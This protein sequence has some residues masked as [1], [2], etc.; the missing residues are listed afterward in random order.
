M[1]LKSISSFVVFV[2]GLLIAVTTWLMIDSY[3]GYRRAQ[4]GVSNL[5]ATGTIASLITSVQTERLANT[6]EFHPIHASDDTAKDLAPLRRKVDDGMAQ[7]AALTVF[8]GR[9]GTKIYRDIRTRYDVV[10]GVRTRIDQHNEHLP[11][12]RSSYDSLINELV[13]TVTYLTSN[14]LPVKLSGFANNYSAYIHAKET[15]SAEQADKVGEEATAKDLTQIG[16]SVR[17]STHV[18]DQSF[19]SA[20]PERRRK[21][22]AIEEHYAQI[23]HPTD[24]NWMAQLTDNVKLA[25]RFEEEL[26][27]EASTKA[28]KIEAAALIKLG[29]ILLFGLSGI[30]CA[31]YLGRRITRAEDEK[32][33]RLGNVAD[34]ILKGDYKKAADLSE[35]LPVMRTS[36]GELC[37]S[38]QTSR[39]ARKFDVLRDIAIETGSNAILV[40]DDK[41]YLRFAS[42][43]GLA[44]IQENHNAFGV[45]SD[46]GDAESLLGKLLTLPQLVLSDEQD[47]NPKFTS[48]SFQ[49]GDVELGGRLYHFSVSVVH[50][51]KGKERGRICEIYAKSEVEV[52]EHAPTLLSDTAHGIYADHGRLKSQNTQFE[53][54]VNSELDLQRSTLANILGQ[55]FKGAPQ[56]D[57]WSALRKGDIVFSEIYVGDNKKDENTISVCIPHFTKDHEFNGASQFFVPLKNIS[58]GAPKSDVNRLLNTVEIAIASI[59]ESGNFS[60]SEFAEI[61]ELA[62][63]GIRLHALTQQLQ[64]GAA[65]GRANAKAMSPA[66]KAL[67]TTLAKEWEGNSD[68]IHQTAQALEEISKH[69]AENVTTALNAETAVTQTREGAAGSASIVDDAVSAVREIEKSSSKISQIIGVIDEIAFQTNLTRA[70][71]RCRGCACWAMRARVLRWSPLRCVTWRCAPPTPQKKSKGLINTSADHV[72]RGVSLVEETGAA[73]ARNSAFSRGCHNADCCARHLLLNHTPMKFQTLRP[74]S[75]KLISLDEERPTLIF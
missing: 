1:N 31:I 58:F 16:G 50:N 26:R 8:E 11:D 62:K 53:N 38:L 5:D 42:G 70:Q 44:L 32:M 7:L 54:C 48:A 33:Q 52:I 74:L 2:C 64:F 59:G 72:Q 25:E 6:I 60:R 55:Q 10:A 37:T 51:S 56:K 13:G 35:A 23:I 20:S 18:A 19:I 49:K 14:E 17:A 67:S 28:Q 47:T 45:P 24:P 36:F 22:N 69:A 30:G 73:L 43:R 27:A 9:T 57:A 75:K 61:S 63:I 4:L 3:Y 71:C 39:E 21:L 68:Q 40:L 66:I 46:S 15:M 29:T 65:N 41:G 34:E 12:M